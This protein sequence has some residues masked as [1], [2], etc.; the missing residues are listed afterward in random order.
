MTSFVFQCLEQ[1]EKL[2]LSGLNPS[3]L[4][5]PDRMQDN[6]KADLINVLKVNH[7]FL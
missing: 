2:A 5:R 6:D 3:Q 4:H 7:L 1:P